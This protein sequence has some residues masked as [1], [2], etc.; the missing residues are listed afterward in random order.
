MWERELASMNPDAPVTKPST[1]A[2]RPVFEAGQPYALRLENE[3]VVLGNWMVRY[4]DL[5]TVMSVLYEAVAN[6]RGAEAAGPDHPQA[7]TR[8]TVTFIGTPPAG[9][10]QTSM[11]MSASDYLWEISRQSV[12]H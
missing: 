3:F 11:S 12:S 1:K 10:P 9:W 7:V 8:T 2:S 5:V 4:D 6:I